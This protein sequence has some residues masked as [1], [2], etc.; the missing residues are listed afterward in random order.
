MIIAL[1]DVNADSHKGIVPAYD[2]CVGQS[3]VNLKEG[4]HSLECLVVLHLHQ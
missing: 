2:R 3:R 1:P 4:T